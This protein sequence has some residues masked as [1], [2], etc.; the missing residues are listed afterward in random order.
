MDFCQGKEADVA[1]F[2]QVTRT[3]KIRKVCEANY[4][5]K[6]VAHKQRTL[7]HEINK[8]DQ[9]PAI[10]KHKPGPF[11]FHASKRMFPKR[12]EMIDGIEKPQI[13]LNFAK[14]T[15]RYN[16]F[17]VIPPIINLLHVGRVFSKNQNWVAILVILKIIKGFFNV[18]G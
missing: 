8:T 1:L 13:P 14:R 6:Q 16:K 3:R 10:T 12:S 7:E 11:E 9:N 4:C 5:P 2:L 17:H 15:V 18:L